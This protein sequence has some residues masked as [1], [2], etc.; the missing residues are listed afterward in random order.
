MDDLLNVSGDLT[1]K[2]AKN[3]KEEFT[4]GLGT[5][6]AEAQSA[7]RFFILKS[8]LCVLSASAVRHLVP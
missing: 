5:F 1:T 2:N 4:E 6:T 3:A 8:F 7:Q